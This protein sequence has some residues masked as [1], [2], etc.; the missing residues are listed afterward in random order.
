[1][2]ESTLSIL[3]V[4]D[5]PLLQVATVEYLKRYKILVEIASSGSEALSIL[6]NQQF[7]AVVSDYQMPGM[8]GIELLKIIRKKSDIPFVLFTGR[9]REDVVIEAIENGADFYLQKGGKPTPQFTELTHKIRTAVQRRRDTDLIRKNELK[10]ELLI[11]NSSDIIRIHDKD[12]LIFFDSP[13]SS[14]ILGFPEGYFIG[15]NFFDYIHSDDKIRI[16]SEFQEIL[17]TT[18]NQTL[19]EYRIQKSDG[20]YL[21]VESVGSNLLDVS[22]I[23][24]IITTTHSIQ[25][26]KTA[27]YEIR[28]M[29]DD[30]ASAYKDLANSEEILRNNYQILKCREI[31]LAKSEERFRNMAERSSDL[32]ILL[33]TNLCVSYASP[34][35]TLITGYD[36]D[37]LIKLKEQ[38]SERLF[39]E[40]HREFLSCVRNATYGDP[41]ENLE[42]EIFKKN[43]EAG[44]VSMSIVPTY[45]YNNISGVQVAIR[46]ITRAKR[47]ELQLRESENKFRTLVEY[48]LD[49][50]FILDPVGNIRFASTSAADMVG[51]DH[52]DEII[53]NKNVIEFVAPESVDD[54]IKDFETVANGTDGYIAQYKIITLK[55]K[56][57]WLESIGK[58]ILFQNSPSILISIRDITAKKLAE[59]VLQ[60]TSKEMELIIRNM[61]SAFVI[62]ESVFDETGKY[63]SYKFG[64]FNDTFAERTK[65]NQL[66]VQGKCVFEVWPETEQ[67]WIDMFGLVATTGTHQIF[68]MFHKPTN[69]W[70]HCNAYRPSKS[71][72]CICAFFDD[73]TERKAEKLAF[74]ALVRSMVGTCGINSLHFITDTIRSWLNADCVLIGEIQYKNDLVNVLAMNLDGNIISDFKYCFKGSPCESVTKNG[75]KIYQDN[76]ASL[77]PDDID[78]QTLKIRGYVGTPLVNSS[79]NPFGI[80][81]ILFRNPITISE[82]LREIVDIIAVKAAAEIERARIEQEL[83]VS[84]NLLSDAMSMS[85]LAAWEYDIATRLFIFN[86]RFYELY[87]TTSEIEGGYQMTIEQYLHKFVYPDDINQVIKEVTYAINAFDPAYISTFEHRIIRRDGIIRTVHVRIAITIDQSGKTIKVQGVNQDITDRKETEER[88]LRANRQLNLLTNITRH[89]ILNNVSIGQIYLDNVLTTYTDPGLISN[90]EK[91]QQSFEGIQEQIEFTRIYQELGSHDPLWIC[92]NNAIP[93]VVPKTIIF[94]RKIA[95]ISVFANPMLSAVF[96]NLLDNSIRHGKKVTRIRVSTIK[97]DNYLKIIWEDDG[98]GIVQEEKEEIFERGFGQ[99]TGFGLFLVREIL[100]FTSISIKENGEWGVGARFEIT[101]PSGKYRETG[102]I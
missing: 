44:F 64:Y 66:E 87:N 83:V 71:P 22:G 28:K 84:K 94:E 31:E 24:G 90:L 75:F 88:T 102:E 12:G 65:L 40:N 54:V 60:K 97:Y 45:M 93:M 34:S 4:D 15:H 61:S 73:I 49:G 99:N 79:G 9:G 30:L 17:R 20:T 33:D 63:V 21:Y 41:I 48:S 59:D 8:N 81:C 92:L 98:I 67:S 26:L 70:Y 57:R 29:A 50:T 58:K 77:F 1:M 35:S 42:F 80:L 78:L 37:E 74:E 46:D 2:S 10:F 82:T 53:E 32:I 16:H 18:T 51:A 43:A 62:Y 23:D 89:D 39:S 52:P 19:H 6:E 55:G 11:Q 7:D 95:D 5:E 91:V 69:K 38:F 14:Q 101:V 96:S 86:G 47:S 3:Y 100:I 27:E 76:V 13:S 25:N 85:H 56:T 72:D 36:P 68:E